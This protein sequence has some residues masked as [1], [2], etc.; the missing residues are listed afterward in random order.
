MAFAIYYNAA[1]LQFLADY[2]GNPLSFVASQRPEAAAYIDGGLGMWMS[3]PP[4]PPEKSGPPDGDALTCVISGIYNNTPL[5]L[6]RFA[7]MCRA[8]A[9][10]GGAVNNAYGGGPEYLNALADDM[11]LTG[12]E[13]YVA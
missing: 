12:T 2:V 10:R 7:E 11:L 1:D 4:A 5:T 13:N 3:S 6:A 8:V 9:L